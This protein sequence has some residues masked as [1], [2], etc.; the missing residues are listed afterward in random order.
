M[1]KSIE[2]NDSNEF[3]N[4]EIPKNEIVINEDN[5]ISEN[6]S[7]SKEHIENSNIELSSEI[8]QESNVSSDSSERPLKINTRPQRQAAKKAENQIRVIEKNLLLS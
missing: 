2:N 3:N 8:F 4:E 5:N 7:I 6:N 1:L